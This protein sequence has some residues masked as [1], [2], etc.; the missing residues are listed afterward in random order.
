MINCLKRFNFADID[1]KSSILVKGYP[2]TESVNIGCFGYYV[3]KDGKK[4]LVD[5]GIEDIDTVN[6]TKSSKDNWKRGKTGMC[7][8]DNLKKTG[9]RPEEIDEV[10]L[11]HSHY[12]H[13]S[14]VCHFKNAKIHISKSE[15]YY[16]RS[17]TNPHNKYLGDVIEFLNQKNLSGTLNLIDN[18]YCSNGVTCKVVGGHTPGS[19]LVF[20]DE[21]LFTGDSIFLLESIEK[22]LPIGF[23]GEEENSLKA[24]ALCQNHK[25][26]I[27]T[28]HDFRCIDTL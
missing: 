8:T 12:D 23:S 9:I 26:T 15:Y 22:N 21:Y 3:E 20:T 1:C 25:G 5:T 24:L 17:K 10:Y 2:E 27:L 16:L 28:G 13:I 14:G 6:L 19:M 11:T 18:E 4:I 7:V